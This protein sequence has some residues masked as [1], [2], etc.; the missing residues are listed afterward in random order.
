MREKS[1]TLIEL[2]IVVLIIGILVSLIAVGIDYYKNEAKDAKA[3]ENMNQI[4]ISAS[5]IYDSQG[6]YDSTLLC[7]S[8]SCSDEVKTNCEEIKKM[9][10]RYP[11]IYT[12]N[13]ENY[14]VKIQLNSGR[15]F[16]IDSQGLA[17][18]KNSVSCSSTNLKCK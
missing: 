10:G 7:C 11:D 12:D 8:N 3:R 16:C 5:K 9:T 14:C 2:L 18:E 6:G 4:R 17:V 13:N 15:W 1:F